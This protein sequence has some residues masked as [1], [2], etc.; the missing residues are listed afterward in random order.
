MST[1]AR[2]GVRWGLTKRAAMVMPIVTTVAT[3]KGLI[4]SHAIS[5]GS[6]IFLAVLALCSGF[7]PNHLNE[8]SLEV[9]TV[10]GKSLPKTVGGPHNLNFG[11]YSR[12]MF[13]GLIEKVV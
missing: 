12:I 4:K 10:L 2:R 7:V 1:A 5:E 9:R 13:V 6:I 11:T 8:R 3:R